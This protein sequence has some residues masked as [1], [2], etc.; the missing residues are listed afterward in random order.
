MRDRGSLPGRQRPATVTDTGNE[1]L[2]LWRNVLTFLRRWSPVGGHP[3]RAVFSGFFAATIVGTV[4]LT[5]PFATESG[6]PANFVTALFTATS[7]IC[8]TGLIVEDTPVY[9]SGFGEGVIA[10]L[11]QIGGIGIMTLASLLGLLVA[12]RFGLRMQMSTQV[13]TK[14]LGLGD[15]RKLVG[16]VIKISLGV[17][18]VVAIILTTRMLTGYDMA[19]GQALWQGVFHA[20][21]AW[22]NAGFS[23]NS[24]NLMGYVS[25]PWVNVPVMLSVIFGGIGFPVLFELAR[26]ARRP[27]EWTMH[28]KV[29]LVTTGVLLGVGFL[30]VLLAE[31]TNPRTLGE[32]SFGGKLLAAMFHSVV[33]RTAGFNT[34]DLAAL[35]PG[36]LL[37]TDVLMFIGGGSGGTAGG[38][39]VTTFALLAFVIMAEVRGQPTVHVFG[40]RLPALVQRQALTI[41]LSGVGMVM[42][43]TI[44]LLEITHHPLDKVLFETISAFGTVGLSTGITY[45]LPVLGELILIALMFIGRLGPITA[46]TALALRERPRKY[47]LPEERPI[48]G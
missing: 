9:W 27:H 36:T 13:E 39:K 16:N 33:S 6:Q 1:A 32:L 24:D 21:S 46:A 25:D 10:L 22:N 42:V 11:F 37:M 14:S 5:L 8:V 2:R 28:T 34:L 48:V 19:F 12:R 17:E 40:R 30:F 44:A 47:E 23:I 43:S 15:V 45:Q 4:L 29:T 3:A 7:A 20:V 41:A 31:W 18:A 35:E 26:R 38:I